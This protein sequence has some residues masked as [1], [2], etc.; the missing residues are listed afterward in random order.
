MRCLYKQPHVTFII[1]RI[2][3]RFWFADDFVSNLDCAAL[4]AMTDRDDES[5]VMLFV[6]FPNF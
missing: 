5:A 6:I 1:S 2:K 4:R 3:T